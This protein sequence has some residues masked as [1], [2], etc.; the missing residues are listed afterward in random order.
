MQVSDGVRALEEGRAFVELSGWGVTLATGD[1]AVAWLNDLVTNRVDDIGINELRRTLFLDRTG[2]VRADVHVGTTHVDD[3]IAGL[4]VYQDPVQPTPFEQLLDP[5]CHS[6]VGS[7]HPGHGTG[8]RGLP[9][10][11]WRAALRRRFR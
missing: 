6:E 5:R 1:D 10:P 4:V 3:R 11:P 9:H 7:R 2:R 8:C